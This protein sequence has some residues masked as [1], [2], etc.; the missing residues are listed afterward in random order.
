[1]QSM[2]N[3]KKQESKILKPGKP[4]KMIPNTSGLNNTIIIQTV[5]KWIKKWNPTIHFLKT[6]QKKNPH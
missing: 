3:S 2:S 4:F 5:P 6:K 1:M